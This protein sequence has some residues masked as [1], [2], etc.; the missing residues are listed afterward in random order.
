M[1]TAFIS[2]SW[3][4][5]AHRQ[6]VHRFASDLRAAGVTVLFD[7]WA[8]RLGDDVTQFMERSVSTADWR[9]LTR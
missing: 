6:W 4:S 5:D 3:E 1:P 7:Q 2:Y 8:V 9:R